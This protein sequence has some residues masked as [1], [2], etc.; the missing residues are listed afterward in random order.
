[1]SRA[2]LGPSLVAPVATFLL[3]LALGAWPWPGVQRG[4]GSALCAIA[5]ST[6]QQFTL[7]GYVDIHLTPAIPPPPRGAQDQ[8]ETDTYLNIA[9][10]GH[11]A[12]MR[13]GLSLRRDAY[14]PLVLFVALM[15][16]APLAPAKRWFGLLL[17]SA[18]TVVVAALSIWVLVLLLLATELPRLYAPPAWWKSILNGLFGLWLTPPSNRVIAPLALAAAWVA[19]HYPRRADP[20]NADPY[21]GTG[22]PSQN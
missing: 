9:V 17:G 4:F 15:S 7:R 19:L 20:C 16:A 22:R 13:F 18:I 2:L 1:M 14:L 8:V 12:P 11:A 10:R 21:A 3:V 5:N 6:L